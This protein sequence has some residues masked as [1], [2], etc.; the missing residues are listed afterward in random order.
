MLYVHT[1]SLA[2][3][4]SPLLHSNPLTIGTV[5]VNVPSPLSTDVSTNS[6]AIL[7]VN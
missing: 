5:Y 3:I 7:V 1:M 4:G 6:A 2:V